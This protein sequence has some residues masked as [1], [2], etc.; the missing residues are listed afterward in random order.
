[1]RGRKGLAAF[2]CVAIAA[3]G[4]IAAPSAAQR[5]PKV[6]REPG[7]RAPVF[8]RG[9]DEEPRRGRPA[10]VARG[11]LQRN[12]SLYGI[13]VS[14]LETVDV[15]QR[16]QMTTARFAQIHNGH[17]VFGATY[18]VHMKHERGGYAPTTVNGDYFTDLN[19]PD[20]PRISEREALA[21]ARLRMRPLNVTRT[22]EHGLTILP[23]R[24]GA[25]TYRFT[26]FGTRLGKVRRFEVFVNAS[27]GTLALVYDN[28]QHAELPDGGSG[29]NSFGDNVTF[30][31]NNPAPSVYEMNLPASTRIQ[32]FD[33]HSNPFGAY[34]PSD[35]AVDLVTSSSP[36]FGPTHT[37][38]G[39]IDAHDNT[40]AVDDYLIGLDLGTHDP[41]VDL[42]DLP[43]TP[44]RSTVNV[45]DP[46][47][48]GPFYNAF[49]S[50]PPDNQ[51]VYGNPGHGLH[52]MPAALDIVAHELTHGLNQAFVG[53]GLGQLYINQSGAMNEAYS[54]YFGEAAEIE[55][56]NEPMNNAAGRM[57]E[58]V[59]ISGSTPEWPCPLRD[60]DP[61]TDPNL[62]D[63]VTEPDNYPHTSEY[64]YLLMD[65]DN[66][67]VHENSGPFAGALWDIRKELAQADPVNGA[68][69]ADLYILEGLQ[70]SG[71]YDSFYRGRLAVQSA[72]TDLATAMGAVAAD[73]LAIVTQEFIDHGI[74]ST[75]ASTSSTN[76]RLLYKDIVPIGD[77]MA[78]PQVSG[79]RFVVGNY[80][81]KADIYGPLEIFVG[82]TDCAGCKKVRVGESQNFNTYS[83]EAPDI[84]DRRAVWTH[85]TNGFKVDVHGRVLGRKVQSLADG[86]GLQWFPSIG[87]AGR[88]GTILAW[89]NVGCA[90]CDSDIKYRFLGSKPKVAFADRR[91]EQILPQA[92]GAW[93]AWW[94][95]GPFFSRKPKI[96]VTNVI[97]G[98]T[99]VFKPPTTKTFMGPPTLSKTHVYWYQ[100]KEFFA[101]SNPRSGK[102]NIVRVRLGAGKRQALFSET[103]ALAP[104]YEGF[105]LE[106]VPSANQRFVTWSDEEFLD[107]IAAGLDHDRVGRDI[108]IL[109]LGTKRIR[110][111]S[112]NRGDQAFP[113]MV[114][115]R[116]G[117]LWLDASRSVTDIRFKP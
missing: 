69:R 80:K 33:A 60:F 57:G 23:M 104:R 31:V 99:F 27:N 17:E 11:H 5:G 12:A 54:D 97:T 73:D 62:G 72:V 79:K 105:S 18:L 103:A 74:T 7:S 117:V 101:P 67:G 15:Q 65:V 112:R 113:V 36:I 85:I 114:G 50:G 49:W 46:L 102:G 32:T 9:I 35:P 116:N 89:E 55:I 93:V 29:E 48:G 20:E 82:R 110:L 91:G 2:A 6:T 19:V 28:F 68:E 84:H 16:G 44:V 41:G 45:A 26:L 100:D 52:P 87:D 47:T 56:N 90:F 95:L 13:D 96:G 107:P 70:R 94:D 22:V 42:R 58:D 8:V 81:R 109:R 64:H 51:M 39:A 66:G 34:H 71:I 77:G 111:V 3:T 75:W 30:D 10:D 59:C 4:A 106:P 1:M 25:L 14:T 83:D 108:Y 43:G 21:W 61:E 92:S 63:A 24:T 37:D 86:R 115:G 38:S 76:G 40:Q 88:R 53:P 98:K 78:A